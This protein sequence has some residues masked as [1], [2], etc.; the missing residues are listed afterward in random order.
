MHLQRREEGGGV[1][2]VVLRVPVQPPA[3]VNTSHNRS[4]TAALDVRGGA[5]NGSGVYLRPSNFTF[6]RLL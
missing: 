2:R 3:E 5:L 1:W 6:T 4:V